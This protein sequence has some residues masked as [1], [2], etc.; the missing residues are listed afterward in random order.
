MRP[1]AWYGTVLPLE[2]QSVRRREFITLFGG[3][4]DRI[5]TFAKELVALQP[6]LIVATRHPGDCGTP[7]GDAD[8]PDCICDCL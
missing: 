7:T 2:G 5:R 1:S 6:D 8:N 4:A 3:A